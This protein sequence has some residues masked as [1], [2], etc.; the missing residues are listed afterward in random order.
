MRLNVDDFKAGV[1]LALLKLGPRDFG[2]LA[3]TGLSR[4]EAL[5]AIDELRSCGNEILTTEFDGMVRLT[6]VQS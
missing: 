6:N 1:L 5:A 4:A 3:E 2:E